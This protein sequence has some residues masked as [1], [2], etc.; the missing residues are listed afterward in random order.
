M[1]MLSLLNFILVSGLYLGIYAHDGHDHSED[2][3]PLGYVKYPYQ[4]QASYSTRDTGMAYH[5]FPL[6]PTL[7]LTLFTY[8]HSRLDLLW[9]HNLCEAPMGAMFWF[10]QKR[11]L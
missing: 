11:P 2:Q 5:P 6:N 1:K 3:I 7:E 9:D 8:S 10:R 4:A